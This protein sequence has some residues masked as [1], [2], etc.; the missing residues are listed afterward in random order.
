MYAEELICRCHLRMGAKGCACE[1][2]AKVHLGQ[3]EGKCL[4]WG[5]LSNRLRS[6]CFYNELV[7]YSSLELDSH[8]SLHFGFPASDHV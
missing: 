1:W 5:Y 2:C 4:C 6:K 8:N 7:L 3:G